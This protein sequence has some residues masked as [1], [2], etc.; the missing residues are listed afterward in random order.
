MRAFKWA[1]LAAISMV[2]AA[3]GASATPTTP[4]RATTNP[5]TGTTAP[6]S[7][8]AVAPSAAV[9]SNPGSTAGAGDLCSLLS[10]SDLKTATGKTYLAGTLDAAGQCNW[11]TDASGANSGDLVILAVQAA[12][13]SYIKSSFGSGGSD[14]TVAGHAAFWN[15]TLGL[16]S[17]WVDIG[18][19]NVLVLSFPSSTELTAAD[20]TAAQSLA[21]IAVGNM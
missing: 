7:A 15:P 10:P 11:N 2:L 4:P 19:G 17:M 14:A 5:A 12:P 3:C 20:Q 1:G 21:E 13:L 16:Q 8:P 9:T 6:A 18:G